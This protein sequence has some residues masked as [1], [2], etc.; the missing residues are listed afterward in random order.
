MVGIDALVKTGSQF[1]LE[2][3][4]KKSVFVSGQPEPTSVDIGKLLNVF[5]PVLPL[6]ANFVNGVL[7]NEMLYPEFVI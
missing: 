3:E 7:L 2:I 4:R 5:E 6:L 1:K